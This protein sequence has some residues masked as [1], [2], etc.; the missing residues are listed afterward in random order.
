LFRRQL[1]WWAA[2]TGGGG[3]RQ[4]SN[5]TFVKPAIECGIPK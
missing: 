5:G 4:V 2:S 3:Y 1:S